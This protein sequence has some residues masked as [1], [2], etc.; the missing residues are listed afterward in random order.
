MWCGEGYIDIGVPAFWF[1]FSD[2]GA[3]MKLAYA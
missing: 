1:F 3:G 2:F